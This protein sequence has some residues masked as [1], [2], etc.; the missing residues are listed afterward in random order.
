MLLESSILFK[1]GK[2]Q[3]EREKNKKY[4]VKQYFMD[5]SCV[6]SAVG[7]FSPKCHYFF[8]IPRN[9]YHW[10]DFTVMIGMDLIQNWNNLQ[11]FLTL[12]TWERRDNCYTETRKMAF[13][14]PSVVC[15]CHHIAPI[16]YRLWTNMFMSVSNK[17]LL[18]EQCG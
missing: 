18:E 17:D 8:L 12:W 4:W 5:K 9:S 13:R 1:G 14:V 6:L 16:K 15:Y 7:T 3:T 11:K 2:G 10:Q